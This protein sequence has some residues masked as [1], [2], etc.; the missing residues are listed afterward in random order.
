M[1]IPSI[2]KKIYF[3]YRRLKNLINIQIEKIRGLDFTSEV[4]LEELGL[5]EDYSQKYQTAGNFRLKKILSSISITQNDSILDFGSG[6]GKIISTLSKFPFKRVDGVEISS[7]LHSISIQNLKKLNINNATIYNSDARSFKDLERY[8]YFYFFNPFKAIIMKDVILNI[9]MS[10][11]NAPRT[12]T[13]IYFNPVCHKE[14]IAS[15][16]FKLIKKRWNVYF[17]SNESNIDS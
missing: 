4:G 8:N 14:I 17:Y 1:K 2:V 5:S 13:I 3:H 7:K 9:E 12:I 16:T 6:K 15:N 11:K 10:L